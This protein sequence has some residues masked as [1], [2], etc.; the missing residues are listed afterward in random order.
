MNPITIV[1]LAWNKIDLTHEFLEKLKL[2]TDIPFK[3][4]F[5]DNAST[6]PI[7]ALVKEYFPDCKL[8]VKEKNVGCPATRNEAMGFAKTDITFWLD[9]DTLVGPKWYEPVLNKLREK[10]VGISGPFGYVVNN[11]WR[12]P[13]PFKHVESGNCDWFMGYLVGFKTAAYKPINDY[14]IPVNMDD[15][16]LGFGIK[17]GGYRAV[18]SEPCYALHLTSQTDRG[19]VFDN[20][21][22]LDEM[23]KN[24]SSK[25]RMF[26]MYK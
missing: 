4:I 21:K 8:I 15:V 6:E 17:E 25:R 10:D 20:K 7:P 26:E 16:E 24:W 3:L 13:Y 1:S 19:W 14:N 23:W 18:I 2:Y 5:T 22:K 11:P 12:H 9:N